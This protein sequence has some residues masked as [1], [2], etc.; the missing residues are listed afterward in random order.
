MFTAD[1][2]EWRRKRATVAHALFRGSS[3]APAPAAAAPPSRDAS[4]GSGGG[5]GGGKGLAVLANEEA[6]SL[7]REVEA[8]RE[9]DGE[10][11]V[12]QKGVGTWCRAVCRREFGTE[13]GKVLSVF[14]RERETGEE[15]SPRCDRVCFFVC[16]RPPRLSRSSRWWYS[17]RCSLCLLCVLPARVAC[18]TREAKHNS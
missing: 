11:E 10:G 14:S 13:F 2:E 18:K 7:L 12:R 4:P 3:S 5:G 9:E 1:G 15:K 17:G 6:D 16:V 8:L